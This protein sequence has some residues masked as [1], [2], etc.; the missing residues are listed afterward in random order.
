MSVCMFIV[1]IYI[2]AKWYKEHMLEST[3]TPEFALNA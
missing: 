2:P 1:K 3:E